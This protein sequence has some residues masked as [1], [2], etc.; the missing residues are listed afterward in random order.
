MKEKTVLLGR[1]KNLVGIVTH[2]DAKFDERQRPAIILLN[3]GL[4]HRVGPNRI[5]VKIARRLA[6]MGFVVLRFDL[7]GIGDSPLPKDSQAYDEATGAIKDTQAVMDYLSQTK[8]IDRFI[9]MGLCSGASNAF[10][11][12]GHDQ[13]VVGVNLIEGFAFPSNAYFAQAYS[14]SLLSL[15][16]WGRLLTGKS[17]FWGLIRGLI[18]FHTSKQ[19]RQLTENLQVPGKEEL[20]SDLDTLIK[21]R[22]QLCFI[23]CAT[24]SA[25]YNYRKIFEEKIN[26]ISESRR[27]RLEVLHDTDHLFTLLHHQEALINIIQDWLQ[28]LKPHKVVEMI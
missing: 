8:A 17:E 14:K 1:S 21:R 4:L 15:K 12:A 16:S 7:S 2:P 28:H 19:T 25:Y 6:A 3:S 18:K 22:V 10:R 26:S 23:Y 27:P 20:L 11:V 24:S 5:Y 13:R 9:L